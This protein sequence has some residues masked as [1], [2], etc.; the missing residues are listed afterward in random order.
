LTWT[1]VVIKIG[2]KFP[3]DEGFFKPEIVKLR[4]LVEDIVADDNLSVL[5]TTLRCIWQVVEALERHVI[6]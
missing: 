5:F 2:V 3:T 4:D 1:Y 6:G